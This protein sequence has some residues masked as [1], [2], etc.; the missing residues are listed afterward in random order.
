MLKKI[1]NSAAPMR[2]AALAIA[3]ALLTRTTAMSQPAET[4][5]PPVAT[6]TVAKILTFEVKKYV[7]TGNTILSPNIIGGIFTNATGEAVTLDQIRKAVGE[8]QL[9]YRERGFA[10]V[11]VVLPQQQITNATVKVNV[12]EGSLVDIKVTGNR[13]YSSANVLRSLPSLHTNIL[14]NSRVFQRELDLANANRD[15]QIYPVANPGPDPGTSA[16]EL[17]VKDRF[18]LHAHGEADNYSTPGTP[19]WRVNLSAQYNNLWQ[20]DQQVGIF[21]AFSPQASKAEG[22]VPDYFFNSP[23]ISSYGGY[24]RLPLGGA[25]SVQDQIDNSANFGYNEATHQ[26][27]LPPAGARPDFT[28]YA[29]ASSSDTGVKL[30]Q[31]TSIVTNNPLLTIK[32]QDAGQNLSI[33]EGIGGRFT[34]PV[35]KSDRVRWSFSAGADWKRFELTSFNTNN[36]YFYLT[37]T[38]E[39]GN[40]VTDVSSSAS[41]QAVPTTE[42]NY[43]PL[44]FGVDFSETDKRGSTTASFGVSYNFA[45]DALLS[46]SHFPVNTN[47]TNYPPRSSGMNY[48]KFNLSVTRDLKLWKEWS[49]FFRANGQ[50][51]D[52]PLISNEQFALGGVNSVRGY[53]EGDEYGDAGWFSSIEART[54]YL[55]VRAGSIGGFVPVWLRA[56]TFFDY[57]QRYLL[58]PNPGAKECRSL[59]GAGFALQANVNNHFDTRI[60]VGWPL[61]N[62]ANTKSG[63]PRVYFTIGGQF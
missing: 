3:L 17:R 55:K 1:Y 48:A 20:H 26:F 8:L 60:T 25:R 61:E 51:A 29:S 6:N 31:F 59:S 33:N 63:E 50:A 16:L 21:Y 35:V 36:F 44:T 15:R 14:L 49:L 11:G 34:F 38:N 12:V 52:R 5:T 46:Y 10:T 58:K 57:G 27:R 28:I 23:L 43:F 47:P 9:A 32:S 41:P 39:Q 18:P 54:P 56:S 22:L 4:S 37:H 62:S 40:P 7:V 2:A 45:G 30:G 13:F 42:I 53:Y 19:D 24:Y